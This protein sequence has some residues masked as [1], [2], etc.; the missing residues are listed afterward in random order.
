MPQA[1]DLYIFADLDVDDV[2]KR[3]LWKFIFKENSFISDTIHDFNLDAE[4]F[5]RYIFCDFDLFANDKAESKLVNITPSMSL[6][7]ITRMI[8]SENKIPQEET[9]ELYSS[10]GYPLQ[11]ETP[12]VLGLA[13]VAAVF[14]G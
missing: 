8:C 11:N 2:I 7:D 10:E 4:L 13:A 1:I 6:N 14:M 9:I 5:I 12:T 3:R